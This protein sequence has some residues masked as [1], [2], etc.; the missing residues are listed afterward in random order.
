[1]STHP[2]RVLFTV[3]VLLLAEIG[4]SRDVYAWQIGTSPAA[5]DV[6]AKRVL[7]MK[8][9]KER[10]R[11]NFAGLIDDE[12]NRLSLAEA[13]SKIKKK[14]VVLILVDSDRGGDE[15]F[16]FGPLSQVPSKQQLD[17]LLGKKMCVD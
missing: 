16:L 3:F 14:G 11:I 2:V 15:S 6:V 13:A 12:S 17:G 1:M 4:I 7:S 10:D 9:C 5:F 8:N